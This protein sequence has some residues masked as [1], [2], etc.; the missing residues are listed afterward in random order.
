[1]KQP[2]TSII[3]QLAKYGCRFTL[4]KTRTKGPRTY[5]WQWPENGHTAEEAIAHLLAGGNVGLQCGSGNIYAFD[6]DKDANERIAQFPELAEAV[7][8]WR[9]DATHKAKVLFQCAERLEGVKYQD[10]KNE[11]RNHKVELL[12]FARNTGG[13]NNAVIAGIHEDGA[14][15]LTAYREIPELTA[16]QVHEMMDRWTNGDH[17]Q[18]MAKTKE[19]KQQN[20]TL[21]PTNGNGTAYGEAAL[22]KELDKL[23]GTQEPGRNIQLNNSALALG[24]LVGGGVL[25][26]TVVREGLLAAGLATGLPEPDT[27]R[28]IDSGIEAGKLQ[29]RGVPPEPQVIYENGDGEPVID[30]ERLTD[31]GNAH[32]F[33]RLHGQDLRW[34]YEWSWLVWTG[35]AW[36]FDR[37]GEVMRRAKQTALTFFAE[38]EKVTEREQRIAKEAEAAT[39]QGDT[40]TAERKT[41]EAK[42]VLALAGAILSWARKSQTRAR[43]E[44]MIALAQSEQPIPVLASEFD[45]APWLLNVRNGTLDLR[46]GELRNHDRADL[47]TVTAPV[48]YDPGS[49]CPTWLAFL[50]RIMNGNEELLGFLQRLIG[51]SLTGDVSEQKLFFAWGTG[52]NGKSTFINTILAMLGT[53][54]AAQAAPDLLTVSKG[55]HPTELADLRGKRLVASVEVDEGKRLAEGLVKQLT[56]GDKVKARYMRQDFFEFDPTHK[57][58][59]VANHKPEIRGTDHAIWRRICL[60]PFDVTIPEAEQDKALFEKLRME[61]P[62]ILNWAMQGCLEWQR[63]GLEVP[64]VVAAATEQYR[65]ESDMLGAFLDE[66]TVQGETLEAKGGELYN[67]YKIWCEQNGIDAKSNVWIAKDLASRGYDKYKDRKGAH[68]IGL[69]LVAGH[70]V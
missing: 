57:L 48:D 27:L 22:Q 38:H 33:A 46:T 23:A 43:L 52:A 3:E 44:A 26:E 4:F 69:G 20:F 61:L 41:A 50:D 47:L 60:I 12:A 19:R 64:A 56:G 25:D 42:R 53:D 8:I 29:P 62:G 68:Y 65:N 15:I 70:E 31:M 40:E 66:C 54:Y 51:Y 63:D 58:M 35:K 34:V 30:V 17:S 49:E 55:R 36:E 59:L 14:R 1:M 9:R 11:E 2:D 13:H 28:T 21:P 37:T 18:R 5:G 32:R 16:G 39:V 7:T 45:N 67:A 10:H 24:Q 6:L